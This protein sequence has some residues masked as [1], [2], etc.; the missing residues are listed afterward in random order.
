MLISFLRHMSEHSTADI[1][2][3]D[4]FMSLFGMSNENIVRVNVDALVD[5]IS[6]SEPDVVVDF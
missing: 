5:A 3:M 1:W 6:A 2:N 4:H